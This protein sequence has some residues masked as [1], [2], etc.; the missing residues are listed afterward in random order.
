MV[1]WPSGRDETEEM[2]LDRNLGELLQELRV[3]LPGVQSKWRHSGS[4][5]HPEALPPASARSFDSAAS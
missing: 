1:G 4:D 3:A 2:R 5:T